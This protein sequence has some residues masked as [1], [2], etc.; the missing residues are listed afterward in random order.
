MKKRREKS[1]QN[2]SLGDYLK[3]TRL[4]LNMTLR[5]VEDATGREVSNAYLSQLETGKITKPSPHVLY[6]LSQVYDVPYE[7]LM[8]RAG[9]I[10]PSK[11]GQSA[12][13]KHG[14]IATLSIDHL[15]PDEEKA[16]LEYLAF[17]RQKKKK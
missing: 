4:G 12:G 16:L 3:A 10:M 6:A 14:K 2:K 1:N 15:S 11:K 7:K 5:H 17:Y 9:Y 13:A 8:E